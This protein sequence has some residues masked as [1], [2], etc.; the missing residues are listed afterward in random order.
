MAIELVD[1]HTHLTAE[2][3]DADRED[4]I[5]RALAA[6]ITRIITIGAGYK[7]ESAEKAI[8]LAEKYP[9]I[10]ASVGVHPNDA[11]TDF[12]FLER[13][14]QLATHPKVVA[15]GETGL[16]FYRDWAAPDLQDKWF[17]LQ[18]ELALEVKKPI[19]I[20][21]RNAGPQCFEV[22]K[23]TGALKVGGVFHC[24]S[25]DTAFAEKLIDIN[26][27]ISIPGSVTF[28]KADAL[29]EVVKNIPLSRIMVETDAPYIAPV[30]HRGKRCETSF[31]VETAK[32]IA[33]IKGISLDEVATAT[34]NTAKKFYKLS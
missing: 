25:E 21:S 5:N 32:A 15:I 23:E 20:H 16:D 33:E 27:I 17:R 19:I 9:N 3:F 30:P 22:L 10:W 6:G 4:V 8:S 24:F 18:I 1:S 34:T 2:E 14:K 31:M 12:G 29:R 26:F 13:L 7:S 28:K 11:E